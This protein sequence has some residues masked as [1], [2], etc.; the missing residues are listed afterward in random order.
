MPGT[1]TNA[2]NLNST[3]SGLVTWDGN[4]VMNTTPLTQYSLLIGGSSNTIT[5]VVPDGI[6]SVLSSNGPNQFP[7]FQ[8]AINVFNIN[9]TQT[10]MLGGL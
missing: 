4:N 7:S 5:N 6:G 9:F 3:I 1:P 10:F 2:M 8:S